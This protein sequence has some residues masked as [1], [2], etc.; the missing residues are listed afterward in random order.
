MIVRIY[1]LAKNALV[2]F[3]EELSDSM[4]LHSSSVNKLANATTHSAQSM[5]AAESLPEMKFD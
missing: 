1:R 4:T 3:A 5:A 2:F